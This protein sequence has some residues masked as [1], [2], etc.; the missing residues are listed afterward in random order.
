MEVLGQYWWTFLIVG[1]GLGLMGGLIHLKNIGNMT[2]DRRCR[3]RSSRGFR[4]FKFVLLFFAA[5]GF[6]SLLGIIGV[7]IALID[8]F[9]AT[10]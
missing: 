7:I 5:G 8:Y 2:I 6:C 1:T 9:K 3:G 4:D 10:G